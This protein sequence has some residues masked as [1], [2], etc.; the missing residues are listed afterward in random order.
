MNRLQKKCAIATAGIHL[1]LLTILIVGPAFYNPKPK[2][3]DTQILN[4]IP[5]N[6]IDADMTSGVRNATPPPVQPPPTPQVQPPLPTPPKPV[7][8]KP[9][10]TDRLEKFFTP[11]PKP[12]PVKPAPTETKPEHKIQ[13]NLT[14]AVRTAPK[15]PVVNSKPNSEPDN[16]RAINSALKTLRSN[17]SSPTE[18]NLTGNSTEAY[19]SYGSV[20]TSVYHQKWVALTPMGMEKESAVVTFKVNIASNGTVISASIVTPSGDA[21]VDRAVQRMLD[22]VAFI[23]AFP[24]GAA[25]NEREYTIDFNTKRSAE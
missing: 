5:A 3:D 19:A 22:S 6:L 10:L 1:L 20:V 9:T 13:P 24:A 25:D 11:T 15:N 23:A 2:A 18:V 16:S 21:N 7:E 17:L 14:P 12:E 4:F 8:P